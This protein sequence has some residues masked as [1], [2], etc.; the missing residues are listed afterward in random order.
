MS[1]VLAWARARR[2][3]IAAVLLPAVSYAVVKLTERYG[4]LT[5][6]KDWAAT[7][8]TALTGVLVHEVPN[9]DAEG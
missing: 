4:D 9:T 7:I 2:K 6:P 1:K 3:A 5:V 8:V